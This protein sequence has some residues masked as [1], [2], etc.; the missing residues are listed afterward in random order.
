MRAETAAAAGIRTPERL[1][2]LR[3]PVDLDVSA[4]GSRAAFT[5]S[6]VAREKAK[7]LEARLWVDGAPATEPGAADA[8][9]RLSPDGSRLAYASDRGHAGRMSLWIHGEGELGSIAGSVEDARWSP[10]ATQLLVLAADIGSDRAGAQTATKI[11]EAGAGEEDPKV[12]RPAQHWRRLF[13]VD[14]A[15][16]GTREGSPDGVNGFEVDWAGGGAGAVCTEE[17]SEG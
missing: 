13:L 7:S 14:A 2:E 4:D 5:V 16:G 3:R 11:T 15:T 6:P 8:A 9:P 12:I 17:P 10:D 1:L